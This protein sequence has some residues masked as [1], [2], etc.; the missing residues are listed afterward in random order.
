M[1]IFTEMSALARE[2]NA[3]NLGQGFPDFDGPEVVKEMAMKAVQEGR[4][5]Y[6]LSSGEPNL[7]NAIAAHA[8]RFYGQTV[9]PDSDVTV[10]CGATEAILSTILGLVNPGDE[11]ILFEPFYD[12]YVPAV[13]FA[14]GT[15]RY[16]P[17]RAPSWSFDPDELKAAFN[18]K[19][20]LIIVNTPHNPTG[21]V[22]SRAELD[23]IADLCQKW[24]VVAA[25]D[26]V[27]EHIVFSGFTHTRLATLPGMAGRTVTISS[28]GKTF[29]FTGWKIGWTIASP[30]LTTAIR[31]VHQYMTFAAATPF[32]HA[33]ADALQLG[34]D[35]YRDLAADYQKRR[36]T[37]TGILEEA[38]Y[39]AAATGGT[40]FLMADI[41]SSGMEDDM[42]FCR[43][44]IRERGVAAIPP[45]AFY[46][47]E[48][49]NLARGWARF[50]FCKKDETLQAV[51]ER[52]NRK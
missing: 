12:S 1:T 35:F 13:M 44:L 22:F 32:Q 18:E 20:R 33:A 26:E 19:T 41:R 42:E 8:K 16:V 45:S 27:Y 6:A 36:D 9:N 30:E 49:K 40:Y 24:N 5:Q 52:L 31:R 25:A 10:T 14:G 23:T 43:W 37:L 21:H 15:P 50:A 34:D 47:A 51:A 2:H 39:S 3:I 29:S 48:N 7:R 38:G 28:Q 17:L 11:V 4:N 46:S